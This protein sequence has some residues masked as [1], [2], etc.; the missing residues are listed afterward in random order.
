M[1]TCTRCKKSLELEKFKKR[2]DTYTKRCL[3][4]LEKSRE[5]MVAY[6]CPHG[7]QCKSRCKDCLGHPSNRGKCS[8]CNKPFIPCSDGHQ[9]CENCRYTSDCPHGVRIKKRCKQ[10][11]NE[12]T[13]LARVSGRSNCEHEKRRDQC[14]I[15][16]PCPHGKV[17][18]RCIECISCE[19]GSFKYRCQICNPSGHIIH[20][21]RTQVNSS[22]RRNGQIKDKSTLG[23]LGCDLETL[24]LHLEKQFV[25]GMTW[26]NH[27]EWHVDHIIPLAYNEPAMEEVKQRL[28]YTNLQPLWAVDNMSKGNRYVG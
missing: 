3:K 7:R 26:S 14:P 15:C 25:D 21:V 17:R 2:G 5:E 24:K 4:C 16:S 23:Y 19:H 10:C 27:G 28:H 8:R 11:K 18:G 20:T 22:L 9:T 12:A 1:Q 13:Q 6:K